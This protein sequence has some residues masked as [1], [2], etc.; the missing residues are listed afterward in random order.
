MADTRNGSHPFGRLMT[1]M[2]TPFTERGAV[3][4]GKARS[5]PGIWWRLVTTD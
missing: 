3:D 1:A 5:S 2:V 4:F